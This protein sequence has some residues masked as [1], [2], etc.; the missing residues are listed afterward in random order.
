MQLRTKTASTILSKKDFS[1]CSS[2]SKRVGTIARHSGLVKMW[3]FE[4]LPAAARRYRSSSNTPLIRRRTVS[5]YRLA[6]RRHRSR[7]RFRA[8]RPPAEVTSSF[9]LSRRANPSVSFCSA[10]SRPLVTVG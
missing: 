6:R 3:K 10:N 5:T 4:N 8:P 2:G 7:R 9:V 1:G